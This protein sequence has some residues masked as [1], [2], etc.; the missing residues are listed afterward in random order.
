MRRYFGRESSI[1]YLDTGRLDLAMPDDGDPIS[2]LS[3]RHE[4]A[5]LQK[6]CETQNVASEPTPNR[7]ATERCW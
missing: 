5:L 1:Q 2:R 6:L 7:P 4:L 3:P